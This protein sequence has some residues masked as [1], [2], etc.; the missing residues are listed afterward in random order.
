[1]STSTTTAPSK[2]SSIAARVRKEPYK[3]DACVEGGLLV[4]RVV[5]RHG[6]QG[7]QTAL[8]LISAEL[9][10]ALLDLDRPLSA[11]RSVMIVFHKRNYH[12]VSPALEFNANSFHT[13]NADT[14]ADWCDGGR[15]A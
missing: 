12:E 6:W 10:A 4:A 8:P 5:E 14:F 3:N 15:T 9:S 13:S 2:A 7:C 1:M 11:W